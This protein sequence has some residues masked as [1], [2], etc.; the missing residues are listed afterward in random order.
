MMKLFKLVLLF[1]P[2]LVL[3]TGCVQNIQCN[4]PY[5]R[6]GAECC[7][8]KNSNSICDKDESPSNI[9]PISEPITEKPIVGLPTGPEPTIVQPTEPK[10]CSL[11][12]GVS[13]ISNTDTK[14]EDF[15]ASA[16]TDIIQLM[17]KNTGEE[18]FK[19]VDVAM[20]GCTKSAEADGDDTW[21]AGSLLGGADGI[22]LTACSVGSL[23]SILH[24][25]INLVYNSPGNSVNSVIEHEV[26]GVL[27]TKVGDTL[28][29][30]NP[31]EPPSSP[32]EKGCS[33]KT[34]EGNCS[35][36]K[37]LFCSNGDL[38]L[39]ASIC[40]C[41]IDTYIIQKGDECIA[42]ISDAEALEIE[43]K[44]H[45]LVN[46]EREKAGLPALSYD[47]DLA[48][49]A[50]AY[51]EDQDARN[52]YG[53]INPE[54]IKVTERA[55]DEG[56]TCRKNDEEYTL[57]ENIARNTLVSQWQGGEK[58]GPKEWR[59]SDNIASWV[60]NGWMNSPE[61]RDNILY[62]NYVKEGIGIASYSE[63]NSHIPY[64]KYGFTITQE[65]C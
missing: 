11:Y 42:I 39:K 52:F 44:V 33:D 5:I 35:L 23:G 7:L 53:H 21:A 25:G 37:P 46:I 27:I 41:P 38:I 28:T 8:D 64:Y 9:S 48:K 40:G 30:V 6:V 1:I 45:N 4:T 16:S 12:K 63:P 34:P 29:K 61:H 56:Y 54:G 15:M 18:M 51:S 20:V 10:S 59:S 26:N 14:C 13:S 60:V 22:T 43:Q 65:F 50:R 36:D 58:S 32:E 3:L 17:L 24:R 19:D 49:V 57:G 47:T 31:S 62:A 55:K 2:I